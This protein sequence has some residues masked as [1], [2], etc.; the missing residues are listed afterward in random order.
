[1]IAH[2]KA[3]PVYRQKFIYALGFENLD[4]VRFELVVALESFVEADDA[5]RK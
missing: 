2:E 5:D 3:F 1:L 4:G